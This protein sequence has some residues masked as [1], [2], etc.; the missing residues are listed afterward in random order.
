MIYVFLSPYFYPENFQFNKLLEELAIKKKVVVITGLPNYRQYKF[1]K[2]YSLLGP[3]KENIY[4]LSVIRVPV[5]PRL[6]NSKLLIFLFYI[7]FLIMALILGCVFAYKNKGN[8]KDILCFGGS[9]V[10]VGLISNIMGYISKSS[11]SIW[12]QDIW[13][14]AISSSVYFKNQFILNLI[15]KLQDYMWKKADNIFCQ[16]ESLLNY[17]KNNNYK[18]AYLM[19]NPSRN[20][21][22]R[23]IKNIQLKKYKSK[24]KIKIVFAGTIGYTQNL[25]CFINGIISNKNKNFSLLI[26]GDGVAKKYLEKKFSDDR[27]KF[28][29]WLSE[30]E[31]LKI[32]DQADL[33]L[34][35]LNSI[36]R[37]SY[38]IPGKVQTYLEYG[39]PILAYNSGAT[40]DLV[41]NNNLGISIIAKEEELSKVLLS[42]LNK[43]NPSSIEKWI[44]NCNNYYSKN[45]TVSKIIRQ[46]LKVIKD[47]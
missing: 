13:P 15:N 24:N 7:S 11:S 45:F 14:E 12:V 47:G 8:I 37:Q 10:F 19:Y 2:G 44:V 23:K 16:S 1:Y 39:L 9:P 35:T 36:G 32:F 29:G 17:F 4:N 43:V 22:I 31:M 18:N 34:I 6:G 46:Y 41:E 40:N 21:Q 38:I 26:C 5:I 28:Y 33:G 20:T 27:I 25:E 42:S 3:Y 30:N